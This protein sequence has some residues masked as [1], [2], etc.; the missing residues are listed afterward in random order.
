MSLIPVFFGDN[1]VSFYKS[2]GCYFIN[3]E[4]FFNFYEKS[5]NM[6]EK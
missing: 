2:I 3:V 4:Y 1:D 5:K 6:F